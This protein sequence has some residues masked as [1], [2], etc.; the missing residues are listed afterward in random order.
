MRGELHVKNIKEK[1]KEVLKELDVEYIEITN[2]KFEKID[3][4]NLKK[5]HNS[6]RCKS[7]KN[8]IN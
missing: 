7:W 1:M 6:S 3:I 5:L 8:Q 4:I 2:R